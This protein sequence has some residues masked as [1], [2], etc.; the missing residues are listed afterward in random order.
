MLGYVAPENLV[1]EKRP[2]WRHELVHTLA[3]LFSGIYSLKGISALARK[4][5]EMSRLSVRREDRRT[6]LIKIRKA[7]FSDHGIPR[8]YSWEERPYLSE[9]QG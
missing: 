9:R 5:P 1:Y 8:I 6:F 7:F 4:Y 2:L 3:G